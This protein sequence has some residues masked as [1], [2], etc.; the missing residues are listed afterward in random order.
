MDNPSPDNEE[1]AAEVMGPGRRW[2]GL[3]LGLGQWIGK[4]CEMRATECTI[5]PSALVFP[6][7]VTHPGGLGW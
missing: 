7:Q 2:G 4:S 3:D 1:S 5:K 6:K